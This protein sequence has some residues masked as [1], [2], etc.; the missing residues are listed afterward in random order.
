MASRPCWSPWGS[1]CATRAALTASRSRLSSGGGRW[2][3]TRQLSTPAPR[4]I[5]TP[6]P[7]PPVLPPPRRRRASLASMPTWATRYDFCPVGVETLQ[8]P[9][10]LRPNWNWSRPWPSGSRPCLMAIAWR[11]L[12]HFPAA[13]S[14]LC[15][16][17][18]SAELSRPT[19]APPRTG[20]VLP[21][22]EHALP[23]AKCLCCCFCAELY[24]IILFCG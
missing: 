9:S 16:P 21:P 17:G 12:A 20:S 10:S 22:A 4:V 24:I 23:S 18:T 1:P 7:S 8:G 5:C 2:P 15:R 11:S 19:R 3:G 14:S 13:R 6:L